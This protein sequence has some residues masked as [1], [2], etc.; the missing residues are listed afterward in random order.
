[1]VAPP[2]AASEECQPLGG[3]PLSSPHDFLVP[4]QMR[5]THRYCLHT[6]AAGF[7]RLAASSLRHDADSPAAAF[8]ITRAVLLLNEPV[9]RE[10]APE[11]A[12]PI[13]DVS[14][15]HG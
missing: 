9:P 8:A 1:M 2:M 10:E 15:V 11:R 6:T 7:V 14:E 5:L 12:H 3:G 13:R 4:P